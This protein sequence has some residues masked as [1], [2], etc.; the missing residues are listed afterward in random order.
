MTVSK[1]LLAVL[2]VPTLS[3][4]QEGAPPPPPPPTYPPAPTYQPAPAYQPAPV[5]PAQ[6]VQPVQPYVAPRLHQRDSWYIGFGL[7]VGGGNLSQGGTNYSFKDYQGNGSTTDVSLNFKVGATL[8]P[9]LLLGFDGSAV[10]SAT[11]ANGIT[12]GVQISNYDAVVTFFPYEQGLFLRGGVGLSALSE[13]VAIAG[14]GSGT[15]STKGVNVL[16]GVGYAWWIGQKFNLTANLDYSAQSY[17]SSS[18]KPERSSYWA[19]WL[20][21]DWY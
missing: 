14:Y 10:R 8:S 4:A 9:R 13:D 21:F 20:G 6:P 7:G 11:D 19:L 5:Y 12:T 3:L 18:D 17:G 15:R 1:L 16:A 2:L